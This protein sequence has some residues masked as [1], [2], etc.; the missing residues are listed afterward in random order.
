MRKTWIA[1]C[2]SSCFS[3]TATSC[4]MPL[5]ECAWC[6][7]W[8]RRTSTTWAT[9][10]E[11]P[12]FILCKASTPRA[13]QNSELVWR[14]AC[15][16][17]YFCPRD[18]VG[19]ALDSQFFMGY[20]RLRFIRATER[21]AGVDNRAKDTFV[22]SL[23][24]GEPPPKQCHPVEQ[25]ELTAARDSDQGA[26]HKPLQ[27][28]ETMRTNQEQARWRNQPGLDLAAKLAC[29][30]EKLSGLALLKPACVPQE[31]AGKKKTSWY[32]QAAWRDLGEEGKKE[33]TRLELSR[34]QFAWFCV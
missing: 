23:S 27:C 11:L 13:L 10:T 24:A 25:G 2:K 34:D 22:A 28:C 12:G 19:R 14:V 18:D 3:P 26:G 4:A 7:V 29:C 30:A 1:S 6:S 9:R 17:G 21:R 15:P 31:D 8:R 32:A 33:V 20:L 16:G 5:P